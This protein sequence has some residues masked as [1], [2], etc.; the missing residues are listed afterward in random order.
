MAFTDIKLKLGHFMLF[1]R[2]KEG[3]SEFFKNVNVTVSDNFN[4]E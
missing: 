4:K 1:A 3:Y 2:I